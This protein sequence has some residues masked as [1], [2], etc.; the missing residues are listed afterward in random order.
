MQTNPN[1]TQPQPT[2]PTSHPPNLPNPSQLRDVHTVM[3]KVA[4]QFRRSTGQGLA[5]PYRL[6][7]SEGHD[8][9]NMGG[10]DF[11]LFFL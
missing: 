8:V 11:F 9:E 7:A 10:D 2:P 6:E 5:G 4:R 1:P 3:G